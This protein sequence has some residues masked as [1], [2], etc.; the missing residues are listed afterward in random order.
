MSKNK[1]LPLSLMHKISGSGV[2]VKHFIQ[3]GK[4]P[5]RPYAHRDDYYIIADEEWHADGSYMGFNRYLCKCKTTPSV[6]EED[7]T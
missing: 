4:I 2:F 6:N 7:T 3:Y 5:M 1:D